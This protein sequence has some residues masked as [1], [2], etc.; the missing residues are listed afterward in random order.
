[1]RSVLGE[2]EF[3]NPVNK[4]S[5]SLWRRLLRAGGAACPVPAF[6]SFAQLPTNAF[7]PNPFEN[8]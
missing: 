2:Q 5:S 7:H 4:S 8:A 6:P 1:M 3:C